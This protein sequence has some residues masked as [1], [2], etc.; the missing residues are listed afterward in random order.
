MQDANQRQQLFRSTIQ[1]FIQ[2]RKDEKL[3]DSDDTDKAAKYDYHTWLADAARRVT[4][5]QAVT[6][7]LK[8][9]HPDARGT[10]FRIAPSELPKHIEVGTHSL[11]H[12]F[13]ED[14]TGNA[15]ALDV[16]KFLKVEFESR[17]L[18]DWFLDNDSDLLAVLHPDVL[19]AQDWAN[20]F[21][22]LVCRDD[23]GYASHPM[24]KQLYWC[25]EGNPTEEAGFHLLQPVFSSSLAQAV[26]LEIQESRF[27]ECN[28]VS[29][30]AKSA[31]TA[32]DEVYVEYRGLAIQKLGSTKPQTVSQLNL[33]RRGMNYLLSSAP[34]SWTQ[35]QPRKLLFI[36]SAL[37]R[38]QHYEG[39][40]DLL[41]QLG[42]FLATDP[43]DNKETRDQRKTIERALV[44]LLT[45]FGLAIRQTLPVGWTRDENCKL[46]LCEQLWLDPER[47]ELELHPDYQDE[48]IAFTQAYE[49][50]DWPDE[51]AGCFANWLNGYLD[52]YKLPVGDVEYRYWAKQAIESIRM[53]RGLQGGIL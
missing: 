11:G 1:S 12:R 18:L 13:I 26:Y 39:V 4:Q 20:S 24:V 53:P 23:S 17:R 49:W 32:H 27:G 25:V 46:P 15:G 50:N 10:N 42:E 34:P 38:F 19:V 47:T 8:A 29:R 33:E 41:K 40:S 16:Y 6:H 2:Q 52:K 43:P 51:V 44:R 21:K 35:L 37:K 22:K 31:G 48:D 9:T 5:I 36:D 45:D 30:Q 28:K 7:V 3:K 14:V